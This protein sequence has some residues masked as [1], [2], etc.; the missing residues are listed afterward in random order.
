MYIDAYSFVCCFNILSW[1]EME[2]SNALDNVFGAVL[3]LSLATLPFLEL[4]RAQERI[5]ELE[6]EL[7][8][9]RRNM[10]QKLE[11]ANREIVRYRALVEVSQQP[12]AL[13]EVLCACMIII[14][15]KIN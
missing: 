13:T 12:S 15:T 6:R 3:K 9:V 2:A 11:A 14:L 8:E 5:S 4:D 10:E 1:H 7:D